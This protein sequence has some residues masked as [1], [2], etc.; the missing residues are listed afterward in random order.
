M[1]PP[2]SPEVKASRAALRKALTAA[3]LPLKAQFDLYRIANAY[4][5]N[6]GRAYSK[7][8]LEGIAA[9]MGPLP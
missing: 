7:T 9:R 3:G 4:A 5:H 8:T 6:M 2:T 1:T